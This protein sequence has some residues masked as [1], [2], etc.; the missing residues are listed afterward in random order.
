MS[1][2]SLKSNMLWNSI[3]SLTYSMCQWLITVLVV[4][5]SAN[6]S[7]SGALAL[8]MAMS[9]VFQPIALYR[10]RVY[11]VSDVKNEIASGV[12][13]ALRLV[14]IFVAFSITLLYA[15]STTAISNILCIFLYL[16]FR[17]G[18]VFID[19][20]HGIDQ[21]ELR[22]DYC[23][24]SN[25]IRGVLM[26]AAFCCVMV[27]TDS[28][29]L[30]IVGMICATYPIII[31]DLKRASQFAS[32]KPIFQFSKIFFL[33]KTCLPSVIGMAA[34]N[35]VVTQ[36]RQYLGTN[37]GQDMLGIYASVC[38]PVV[39]IQACAGYIYAP[40]LGG[41]ANLIENDDFPGF[42]KRLGKVLV[43]MFLVFGLGAA[44]FFFIGKQFLT[45]VFGAKI[46]TY[47]YLMY[48]A[49]LSCGSAACIAFLGD[50]LVAKRKMIICCICNVIALCLSLILT[51]FF[52]SEFGMNGVSLVIAVSYMLGSL[53]MLTSLLREKSVR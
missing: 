20:L 2:L 40:L 41:F 37:M 31:L 36:A 16:V 21:K 28:L 35:L 14:T 25:A 12:Y 26:L 45:I 17:A 4:R 39:I 29:N 38:T 7:A 10:I 42:R 19:V 6:F 47:S 23:G 34:C 13:V 24:Q 32:V 27:L 15:F 43:A 5:L 52:I 18:D 51:P 3:G 33:L 30:S 53:L 49:I 22:M 50:L 46:S 11:Q 1:Q 48:A 44:G 9:N 8:A